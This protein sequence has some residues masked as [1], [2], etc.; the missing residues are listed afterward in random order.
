MANAEHL[1]ILKKGVEEWNAWRA[2]NSRTGT[3]LR[4]AYL[5]GVDLRNADLTGTHLQDANLRRADL[6][7]A[8]LHGANFYRANL[9]YANLC[10]ADL[11]DANLMSADLRDSSLCRARLTYVNLRDA[12]LSRTELEN[13]DFSMALTGWTVFG[14]LDLSGAIGLSE[15]KHLR[16]SSV[17]TDTLCLSRGKIP[18]AFLR[19]CG[20]SD[21]QVVAAKLEDPD[22]TSEQVTDLVYEIDRIKADSPIQINPIFISYRRTDSDFVEALESCLDEKRLRYWRDVHDMVSG[23]VEK[24]IESAIEYNRIMLLVLSKDSVESDWVEWEVMKARELEKETKEHVLCPI[25]LD[26]SWKT[27]GSWS[28]VLRAQVEKYNILDFSKWEDEDAMGAAFQK[29][30]DGLGIYYPKDVAGATEQS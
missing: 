18:G 9:A 20:L 19:G 30:I 22:L 5:R 15:I 14:Q 17:G 11:N 7:H 1:R 27:C 10:D 12:N 29:L 6:M 3:D 13:A 16:A 26:D 2:E 23:P 4:G 8:N 25:A 28:R 24:Q 21:W